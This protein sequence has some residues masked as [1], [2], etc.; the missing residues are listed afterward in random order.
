MPSLTGYRVLGAGGVVDQGQR[1]CNRGRASITGAAWG[2][3]GRELGAAVGGESRGVIPQLWE[4]D[5]SCGSIDSYPS[6]SAASS[7]DQERICHTLAK[8]LPYSNIMVRFQPSVLSEHAL[9]KSIFIPYFLFE[10]C[11]SA[12][13]IGPTPVLMRL[14]GAKDT[15]EAYTQWVNNKTSPFSSLSTPL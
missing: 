9:V 6:Q 5:G 10:L 11:V 2:E 3:S 8:T 7:L 15:P 12:C 4:K 14:C 1:A 13:M